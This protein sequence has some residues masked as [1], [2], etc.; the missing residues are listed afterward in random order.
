VDQ[1]AG[2]AAITGPRDDP[3]RPAGITHRN[4]PPGISI[5]YPIV[6]SGGNRRDF[7]AGDL[8]ARRLTGQRY[9]ASAAL[10][11]RC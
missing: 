11:T 2:A 3:E 5:E 10:S 6:Y 1:V 4:T 8:R 9:S 7:K